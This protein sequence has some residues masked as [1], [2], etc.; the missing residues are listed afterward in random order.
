MPDLKDPA[1]AWK[2]GAFIAYDD[3]TLH[4]RTQAVMVAATVFEGIKAF[5]N[6]SSESL[7]LFRLDDHLQRLRNSMKMM[8]MKTTAP[9][10]LNEICVEL[11]RRNE[12]AGNVHMMPTTYVG[13][14]K[15]NVA[16]APPTGEGMF[17]T[18][19]QRP[20]N[21]YLDKGL[22]VSVSSW[23]RI[24]DQT[25]P[26]RIKAAGNYQNGRLA[27]NEAWAN[28]YDNCLMLNQNGSVSE[29]P[30]ACVLMVN[31]GAVCT[32]PVTDGI[33]ESITRESLMT[34][35]SEKLGMPVVERSMNRT[36]LYT[37]DEILMCGSGM[38]VVPV[39]SVDRIDVGNGKKGPVT[40][41]IQDAYFSV[42]KGED[43]SHPE[44]RTRVR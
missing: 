3:C 26:P 33:L 9:A 22:H 25:V 27:L 16:L 7:F 42:G 40:Q 15:D 6:E 36:E 11:L 31:N 19:V 5:W 14:G 41:A 21:P 44:W 43:A 34:L 18:A 29:G 17:I 35:F 4:V 28:G 1:W 38:D 20:P 13:E 24:S 10:D 39:M 32:P 30:G 12:F 2:N 23:A 37:A 8:R